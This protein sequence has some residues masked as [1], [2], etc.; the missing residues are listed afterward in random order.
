MYTLF[1]IS[2][3]CFCALVLTVVA[4]NKHVRS[5]RASMNPPHDFAHHLFTAAADQES[6]GPR[7]L[8]QQSVKDIMAKKNYKTPPL[9]A[10]TRQQSASSKLF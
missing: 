3:L 9:Q 8:M 4:I 5:S 1:V 2:A 7:T 10:N 6:Y